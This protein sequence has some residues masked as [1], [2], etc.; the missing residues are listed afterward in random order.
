MQQEALIS[1]QDPVTS[2]EG[3]NC[4]LDDKQ[5]HSAVTKASRPEYDAAEVQNV[6]QQEALT[7]GHDPVTSSEGDL[8]SDGDD[9]QASGQH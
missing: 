9:V 8:I 3:K 4:V 1:G 7:S 2:S 5:S 6:L